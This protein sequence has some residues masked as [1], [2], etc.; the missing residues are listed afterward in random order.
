MVFRL[1]TQLESFVP[2]PANQEPNVADAVLTPWRGQF[3]VSGTR[4]SDRGSNVQ[5][6]VTGV[7]TDGDT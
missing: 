7:E 5:I 6:R 2:P 3:L 4:A 1:P